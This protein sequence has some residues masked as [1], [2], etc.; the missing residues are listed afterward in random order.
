[1]CKTSDRKFSVSYNEIKGRL[2]WISQ[3]RYCKGYA[4]VVL[5]RQT[6][7]RSPRV[8]SRLRFVPL[9]NR[10]IARAVTAP[11]NQPLHNYDC[12]MSGKENLLTGNEKKA[13]Y[14]ITVG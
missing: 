11:M 8:R 3:Q 5:Q 13:L 2:F 1:M 14:I 9:W 4:L 12:E 6:A 7:L 10:S